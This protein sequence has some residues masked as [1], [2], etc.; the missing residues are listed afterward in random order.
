[1]IPVSNREFSMLP[2]TTDCGLGKI[3]IRDNFTHL[4]FNWVQMPSKGLRDLSPRIQNIRLTLFKDW[5]MA[6]L[7]ENWSLQEGSSQSMNH[8]SFAIL[9]ERD[10]PRID[11]FLTRSFY[12][13]TTVV[14]FYT[15]EA[16]QHIDN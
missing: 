2:T 10:H 3:N 11:V 4:G 16:G 13:N 12:E 1:M 8:Y 7:P 15:P 6:F 9:D 5:E 14:Q